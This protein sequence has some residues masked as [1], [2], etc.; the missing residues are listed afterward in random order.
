M[1]VDSQLAG[2]LAT[3][4]AVN[5]FASGALS[6]ALKPDVTK[7]QP[8]S[9][10]VFFFIILIFKPVNTKN[11]KVYRITFYRWQIGHLLLLQTKNEV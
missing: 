10:V 4:S 8:V 1:S 11:V 6:V 7:V 3:S 9:A 5:S 2:W